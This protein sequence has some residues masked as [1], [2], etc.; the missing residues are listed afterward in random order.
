MEALNNCAPKCNCEREH[1]DVVQ[2]LNNETDSLYT[3]RDRYFETHNIEEAIKKEEETEKIL[4]EKLKI[5]KQHEH[6]VSDLSRAKYCF[7]KG[8]LLNVVPNYNKEAES[9]LSKSIKLDPKLVD[10]WNELGECYWK[11]DD[12]KK[13]INCF[14]GALKEKKN[15]ISL[16]SLSMLVRQEPAK[17]REEKVKNIEK[18]LTYAKE[19][20][21]LDPQDGL[22]WTV[23]G[24]AYLS[25]FFGIQQNPKILKQCLSAYSQAEKDF[26]A[27][28]TPDLHYNKGVTLKYEEE[29]KMALE[30][31]NE[32]SM[33]NPT[34][35]PPKVKEKQLVQYLN[36]IKEFVST[37][38]K[39][40]A[41]RLQQ[42]L[43]S[44]DSK[45][46]GPYGGGTYT[47]PNGTKVKLVESKLKHLKDG[48]NEEIVVLGKVV[49][50][51]RNEDTVPFTFCMVDKDGTCV[52]VTIFNIADGKGVI[53]GDSVAI[54]EPFVTDVDF[55]YKNI[56]YKFRLIRVEN[57]VILVVNGRKVSKDL[58]AEV[59]MSIFKKY[60]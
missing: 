42:I 4:A 25:S 12:L 17:T 50:S 32:A 40:K 9:L 11:N 52:V 43:Q 36:D 15:K 55:S 8:K 45:Q 31:F 20:V 6:L 26:V 46:L 1:E 48:I 27:K 41:K 30:S 51:V 22:S 18:G 14:E 23:L 49:C 3:F 16:R 38:G 24:N 33:Y 39:M 28:S 37:S 44:I 7:L 5:F 35:D 10:A 13:S 59:Q 56:D 60:D 54:A 53:I 57:P 29:F 2:F 47:S 21:Q 19:A 34:W 58:Q